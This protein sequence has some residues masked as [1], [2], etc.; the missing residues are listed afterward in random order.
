VTTSLF[1]GYRRRSNKHRT[2]SSRHQI[3]IPGA[4]A[5]LSFGLCVSF[6][7]LAADSPTPAPPAGR[8]PA[9]PRV[10]RGGW[11]P[12]DPYQY[13][14]NARGNE[15]L[16]GF[17]VE[18]KED[19]DLTNLENLLQGRISRA[20]SRD[21]RD[22]GLCFFRFLAVGS[23]TFTAAGDFYRGGRDDCRGIPD[24]NVGRCFPAQGVGVWVVGNGA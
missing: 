12:W 6:T 1:H 2:L 16:T 23:R 5:V 9:E 24:S 20:L 8:Q 7:C 11:Y 15:T 13:R 17:D 3:N 14:E 4:L 21:R 18:I 22:L 19:N 10:L